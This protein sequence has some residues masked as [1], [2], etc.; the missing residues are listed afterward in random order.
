M[1]IHACS[2]RIHRGLPLGIINFPTLPTK[3][4]D[5]AQ[6]AVSQ[7]PQETACPSHVRGQ[8]TKLPST[9]SLG[10]NSTWF[11]MFETQAIA[12]VGPQG[13]TQSLLFPK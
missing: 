10:S 1:L 13:E 11:Q 2:S 4:E 7:G 8:N 5:A 9:R 12:P 3:E 6:S